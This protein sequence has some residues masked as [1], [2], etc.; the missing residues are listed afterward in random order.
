MISG[1]IS[2]FLL[3]WRHKE[4]IMAI[5]AVLAVAIAMKVDS[6]NNSA[7]CGPTSSSGASSAVVSGGVA[8]PS[9]KNATQISSP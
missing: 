7:D 4:K 1:T 8:Y 3:A 2:V 9:D 6:D 5:I